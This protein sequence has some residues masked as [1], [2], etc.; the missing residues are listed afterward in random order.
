MDDLCTACLCT[1]RNLY[2]I[3]ETGSYHL[4]SQILN[5]IPVYDFSSV[6][7]RVCWECRALLRRFG[8]FKALVK[9][10]YS[11]LLQQCHQN[12]PPSRLSLARAPRL[13]TAAG[14]AFGWPDETHVKE[15]HDELVIYENG[16]EVKPLK[17]EEIH[18]APHSEPEVQAYNVHVEDD[19]DNN[20]KKKK[21]TK[22]T[23]KE[24]KKKV[25][26]K[27]KLK[28]KKVN[29]KKKTEEV[30]SE[31]PEDLE[32]NVHDDISDGGVGD[33]DE[34]EP[35]PVTRIEETEAKETEKVGPRSRKKKEAL[36]AAGQENNPLEETAKKVNAVCGSASGSVV[37]D[38]DE[39]RTLGCTQEKDATEPDNSIYT[40]SWPD[41]PEAVTNASS[42]GKECVFCHKQ[43]AAKT[44]SHQLL[45]LRTDTQHHV[46]IKNMIL[47]RLQPEQVRASHYI[48]HPCWQK[49][50][51]AAKHYSTPSS[52]AVPRV[53][54]RCVNCNID[55]ER[56]R[57]HVLDD[58]EI[59][60]RVQKQIAPRVAT[61]SDYVCTT[62]HTLIL[63]DTIDA[64][65][66]EVNNANTAID[67]IV[68]PI[69]G[70]K[71]VCVVC[72]K[73]LAGARCHD[74]WEEKRRHVV[75]V[76]QKWVEPREL[77]PSHRVCHKCFQ[78]A[79]AA[80]KKETTKPEPKPDPPD[81]VMLPDIKRAPD[82]HA[83]CI[84][85][86]CTAKFMKSVPL[87]IRVKLF[88]YH[89]FYVPKDCRICS[90]HL[91]AELWS[92][93]VEGNQNHY[94]TVAYVDDFEELLKANKKLNLKNN[95]K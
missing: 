7:V 59:L 22:K 79:E 69:V 89:S 55:V 4:Y 91:K 74:V 51:R 38:T 26:S 72:G 85:P 64:T 50:D 93:L 18:E 42:V 82:T 65:I 33:T 66:S 88:I 35:D 83:K 76:V 20:T 12:D 10:S 14:V 45:A 39:E 23:A 86:K 95:K 44:R 34:I 52:S 28:A 87:N 81:M 37:T 75:V 57:R 30:R 15:E 41:V 25:K 5:E 11:E 73:S 43:F 78:R 61:S 60:L 29:S 47:E 56:L 27:K 2:F 84:F 63:T 8:E 19:E 67:P 48:C 40:S 17:E 6:C 68:D 31:T 32:L 53:V 36:T 13:Q 62:C 94:F 3:G 16:D 77:E 80:Y 92:E 21:T 1:G 49:A 58:E 9:R 46:R 71:F 54:L 24:K 70:H 90:D